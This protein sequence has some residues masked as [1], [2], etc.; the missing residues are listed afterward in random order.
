MTLSDNTSEGPDG[1]VTLINAVDVPADRV[2]EFLADW[3]ERADLMSTLPGFLDYTLHRAIAA[4]T[5][6]Q[7]INVAHWESAEAFQ[8]ALSNPEFN[9]LRDTVR[10]QFDFTVTASPA[11]YR[12]VAS[13]NAQRDG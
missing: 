7:L 2:D 5:H 13:A 4:D 11:L 9:E 6:F 12:P 8:A 3:Q 1:V 10:R